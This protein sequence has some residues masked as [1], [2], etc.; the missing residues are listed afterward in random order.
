MS[1]R[2]GPFDPADD[3]SADDQTAR[4]L[5]E[6]L[7]REAR[8]ITPSADGLS[9]IREKIRAQRPTR[10]N[11]VRAFQIGGAGLATAAVAII[12][13]AV[14]QHTSGST[15][16][17]AATAAAASSASP[18]AP[19]PVVPPATPAASAAVASSA[20]SSY[21]VWI[22]YVDKRKDPQQ[23]LFR[24]STTW[25]SSPQHTF[26]KDAVS[27]MLATPA[28]DPDYT[29]YW[30]AGT[31]LLSANIV[32][33]TTAVVNL[34]SEASTGPAN[35]AAI[36]AQQLLYTIIAAA[37]KIDS[38]QLQIAGVPVSSLWGTPLAAT[39]TATASATA[40]A[41]AGELAGAAASG[42]AAATVAALPVWQVW[43]HVWI[44]S[45]AQ[46]ATVASSFQITGEA[47]VFEGTVHWQILRDGG[48]LKQG[49]V[50]ATEGAPGRGTWSVTVSGLVPGPYT[51]KAYEVSAKDGSIT[52]EDDKAF[53][54]S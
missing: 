31:T 36:S 54:V 28:Q 32:G 33:G 37:P 34:S 8:A 26:V 51:V 10:R 23:L 29:S 12:G 52:Y 41:T 22:Y 4:R 5:R 2:P 30:P 17:P 11:W 50:T 47:T 40:S 35:E 42:S 53:T 6:V 45:P 18:S 9:M 27:A 39:A 13:V 24:E 20:P 43:G 14:V 49:S 3:A 48:L 16:H 25:P 44:T 46:D 1:D 15:A 21:P 7:A 38:L 19:A